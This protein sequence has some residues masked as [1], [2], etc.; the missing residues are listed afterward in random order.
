M[1]IKIKI[2][3]DRIKKSLGDFKEKIISDKKQIVMVLVGLYCIGSFLYI[4]IGTISDYSGIMTV[5]GY[6]KNISGHNITINGATY[7][8]FS[9][10]ESSK[11]YFEGYDIRI[12]MYYSSSYDAYVWKSV[13]CI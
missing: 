7:H 11:E 3:A 2:E 9:S 4:A 8:I 6:C 13:E 10:L 1:E 5:E 12:V